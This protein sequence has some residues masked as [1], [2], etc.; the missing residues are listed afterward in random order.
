MAA[1]YQWQQRPRR[2]TPRGAWFNGQVPFRI[3]VSLWFLAFLLSVPLL[4]P[5]LIPIPPL[6][7]VTNAAALAGPESRF[8]TVEG[9]S[10]HVETW[11]PDAAPASE[12][13]QTGVIMLHGFGSQTRTWRHLGEALAEGATSLGPLVAFDRPGFGL[14]ERPLAGSWGRDRNPYG[15]EAQVAYTIGLMD[16]FGLERA[17]LVGHS[18]GGS[19][20]LQVALAHP[21]RVAGLVLVSPA[22]YQGG[23]APNWTRPLLSTPQ[24]NRIGPLLMRQLAGEPGENFLRAA[25]HDPARLDPADEAAYR[26]ALGVENWDRALWELVKASRESELAPFLPQLRVPTLVIT[27]NQDAIVPADE[28]RRLAVELPSARF[29][30]IDACGHVAHEECALEVIE[31]VGQWLTDRET[32]LL[33]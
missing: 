10:L 19:L 17:L 6:Q 26:R 12:P 33:D 16:A 22:V 4:G 23:G 21:E 15:P 32:G 31:A 5:L 20:A 2:G 14:T 7:G 11:P 8:I 1:A 25:Y 18:A 30:G 29:V 13:D 28:S 27:G 9:V 3:K 24:L